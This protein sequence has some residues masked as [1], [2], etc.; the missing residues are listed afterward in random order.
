MFHL[1]GIQ[2][3]RISGNHWITSYSLGREIDVYDNSFNGDLSLSLT[4]QLALIYRSLVIS[5]DDGEEVAPHIMVNVLPVQQQRGV[6]ECSVFAI[7]L[8]LHE[9]LGD[10]LEDIEFDQCQMRDHLLDCQKKRN[11]SYFPTKLKCG[12]KSKHFPYREIELF[13][14]CLMLETN[15]EMMIEYE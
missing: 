6:N 4:H 9:L 5:K 2:I 7:A 3:H 1:D 12:Y 14:T 11:F 13:C 15:G 8:A 10:N